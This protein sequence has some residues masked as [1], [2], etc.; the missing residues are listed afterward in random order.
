MTDRLTPAK[1]RERAGV[2]QQDVAIVM[3]KSVSTVSKWEQFTNPPKLTLV[4]VKLMM[5]A[6]SASLDELVEAFGRIDPSDI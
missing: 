4:E 2:T 5:I 1:L 6:Y 3:G